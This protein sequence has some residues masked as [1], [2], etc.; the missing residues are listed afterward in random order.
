[1]KHIQSW[2]LTRM[3][4]C[5]FRSPDKAS[6][7]FPAGVIKYSKREVARRIRSLLCATCAIA[8]NFFTR[9]PNA[10][11]SVPLSR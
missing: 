9:I 6:K 1:V 10:T 5:P 4:C 11:F 8:S 3:L 7:R 2:S